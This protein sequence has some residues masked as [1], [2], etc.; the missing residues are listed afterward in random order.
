MRAQKYV[1]GR[2]VQ[3]IA[4]TYCSVYKKEAADVDERKEGRESRRLLY[5]RYEVSEEGRVKVVA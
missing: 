2:L 4:R 5:R 1:Y 3:G